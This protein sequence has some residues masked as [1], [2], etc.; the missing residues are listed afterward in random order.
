LSKL[1]DRL[2]QISNNI[3]P[4]GFRMATA[5]SETPRL[6]LIAALSSGDSAAVAT[7]REHADAVIYSDTA[8][9]EKAAA[10]IGDMPWGASLGEADGAQLGKLKDKGCDFIVFDAEKAPLAV[11]R[12]EGMGRVVELSPELPDGLVRTVTQLPI[13]MALIGGDA[14]I[15]V[16]RLMVCQHISNLTSKPLLAHVPGDIAGEDLRELWEAGL[17][18]VVLPISGDAKKELS[19]L[20]QAIDKL[21]ASRRRKGGRTEVSLPYT[22]V[23]EP[24]AEEEIEEDE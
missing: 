13:D 1:L 4:M 5:K 21:P 20:K 17:S 15:S 11:L 10:A 9:V 22:R 18:G 2:N 16:R 23:E 3:K 14:A 24:S 8:K 6:L 7:A 12:D 19:T